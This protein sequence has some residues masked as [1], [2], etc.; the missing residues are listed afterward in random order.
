MRTTLLL[1]FLLTSFYSFSQ[2][3]YSDK[4][5]QGINNFNST[6]SLTTSLNNTN[7]IISG[8]GTSGPV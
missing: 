2:V 7:L 3:L 8:N 4:F 5:D 6:N 1:S